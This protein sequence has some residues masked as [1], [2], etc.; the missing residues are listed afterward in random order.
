MH[1]CFNQQS[2]ESSHESVLTT[3]LQDGSLKAKGNRSQELQSARQHAAVELYNH[4]MTCETCRSGQKSQFHHHRSSNFN[5]LLGHQFT[6]ESDSHRRFDRHLPRVPLRN[7]LN[8]R[9]PDRRRAGRVLPV[10][11]DFQAVDRTPATYKSQRARTRNRLT[12]RDLTRHAGARF[13]KLFLDTAP[14]AALEAHF[15]R[16]KRRRLFNY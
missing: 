4:G 16:S 6:H 8:Q 11:K 15:E 1:C 3:L 7:A 13:A 2:V 14:F 10:W 5:G 9:F 12:P